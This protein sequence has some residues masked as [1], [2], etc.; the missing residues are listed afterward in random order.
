MFGLLQRRL[1]L[2]PHTIADQLTG[3]LFV[4]HPKPK[5]APAEKVH[6][7]IREQHLERVM[8]FGGQIDVW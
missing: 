1:E 4:W 5:S 3:M 7:K 8:H 6:I 2:P